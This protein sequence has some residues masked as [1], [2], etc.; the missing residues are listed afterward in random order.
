MKTVFTN[1]QCVHVWA[2]RSQDEGRTNNGNIY[3]VGDTIYSYG[4]HFP[5][6]HFLN[7]NDVLLNDDQYSISTSKHQAAVRMATRQYNQIFVSTDIMR[8]IVDHNRFNKREVERLSRQKAEEHLLSATKR[9]A[10]H[11]LRSDIA[12][13][14]SIVQNA[15]DITAAFKRKPSVSFRKFADKVLND[16]YSDVSN[17]LGEKQKALIAGQKEKAQVHLEKWLNHEIDVMP[18]TYRELVDT[19]LRIKGDN[20]QTSEGAQFPIDDAKSAFKAIRRL[21]EG[22]YSENYNNGSARVKLGYYTIDRITKAGHVKAGC[23]FVKWPQIEACARELNI[24]P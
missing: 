3:F 23:H 10:A 20:I 6:G 15:L 21:K 19:H 18:Y 9:H 24:Y 4:H 8:S 17:E 5:M 13:A 22:N 16:N 14:C 1:D 12:A 11:T 7:K 2:Q